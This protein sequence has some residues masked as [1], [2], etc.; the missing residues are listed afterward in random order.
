MNLNE[1]I[2]NII[3]SRSRITTE[4]Q[5]RAVHV[6]IMRAVEKSKTNVGKKLGVTVMTEAASLAGNASA[7]NRN[8]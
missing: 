8:E 4:E 5:K 6:E 7:Q 3:N 2:W 1:E